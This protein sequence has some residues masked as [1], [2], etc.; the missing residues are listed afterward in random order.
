MLGDLTYEYDKAGNRTMI[1]GSFARTAVPQA[2]AS[3]AY[4]AYNR[5]ME[6]TELDTLSEFN[7]ALVEYSK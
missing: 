3:T 2:I 6:N 7:D 5:A 4:T 1:G